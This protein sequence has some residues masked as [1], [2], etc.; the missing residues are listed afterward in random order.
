MMRS[1]GSFAIWSAFLLVVLNACG[2]V[3]SFTVR[4]QSLNTFAGEQ[5]SSGLQ[6]FKGLTDAFKNDD[7]LGARENAGLKNGP[8]FNDNVSINGKPVKGAVAGQKLTVVAGRARVKIPVNCQQG[9][10]E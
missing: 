2:S 7:S 10:C 1:T 5:V 8:A 6:M 9:D 4:P 3:L